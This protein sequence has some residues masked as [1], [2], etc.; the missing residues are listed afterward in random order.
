MGFYGPSQLIQDARR[1]HV[2]VL[3]ADAAWSDWECTQALLLRP[4]ASGRP[5]WFVS[6]QGIQPQSG[7]TH[8]QSQTLHP[9]QDVEDLARRA[10]LS[11]AELRALANAG[12]CRRW[13]AIVIRR[14]GPPP[15]ARPH[16]NCSGKSPFPRPCPPAGP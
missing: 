12:P 8:C 5:P 9:F 6:G 16:R 2:E 11:A 13:R 3:P 1:H 14:A 10:A 4:R 15:A 7:R